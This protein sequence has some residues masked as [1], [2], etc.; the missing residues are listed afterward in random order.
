MAKVW[1]P[2]ESSGGAQHLFR[3]FKGDFLEEGAF[4]M[5][6]KVYTGVCQLKEDICRHALHS[7]SRHCSRPPIIQAL[8][9]PTLGTRSKSG[10]PFK[11]APHLVVGGLMG[12]ECS[13]PG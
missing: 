5:D 10:Y 13:S 9:W 11:G 4:A 2:G 6:L 8:C 7:F 12:R 3:T 1:E